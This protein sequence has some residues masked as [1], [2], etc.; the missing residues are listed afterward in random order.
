MFKS[1][2]LEKKSVAIYLCL[3]CFTLLPFVHFVNQT[4]V[5][6]I[7]MSEFPVKLWSYKTFAHL[8]MLFG[9]MVLNVGFPD[10]G[11][12][13]NPDVFAS[14]FFFLFESFLGIEKTFN[15]LLIVVMHL[16]LC[17]GYFLCRQFDGT[18]QASLVGACI[19]AWQPLLIRYG[20]ASV[21]TDIIHLWLMHS[22]WV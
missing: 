22:A 1:V 7:P 2:R 4:G 16:N 6:S 8:D 21:I 10:T 17:A 19:F 15:L 20:F 12:L 9:G 5:V 13:N 3:V 14:M 18:S 11:M